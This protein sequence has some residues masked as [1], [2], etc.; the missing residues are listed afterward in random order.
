MEPE[1]GMTYEARQRAVAV[2]RVNAGGKEKR[3]TGDEWVQ[4]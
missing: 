1:Y 3:L 2:G 4:L